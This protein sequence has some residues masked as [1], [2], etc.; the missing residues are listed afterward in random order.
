M[1]ELQTL[2]KIDTTGKLREWTMV[3]EDACFHA[4]KGVVGGKMI[5]LPTGV[6]WHQLGPPHP[7]L[8][9]QLFYKRA[10]GCIII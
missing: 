7:E 5:A 2:Y 3:I 10:S 4:V 6:E 9:G 8:R 1:K